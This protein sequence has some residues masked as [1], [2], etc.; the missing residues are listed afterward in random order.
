MIAN[1][2]SFTGVPSAALASDVDTLTVAE[3][4]SVIV[5]VAT[6][7]L[8]STVISLSSVDSSVRTTVSFSSKIPSSIAVRSMV[9]VV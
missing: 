7:W 9:A 4:S 6:F 8:V 1:W 5:T 3:S 2:P